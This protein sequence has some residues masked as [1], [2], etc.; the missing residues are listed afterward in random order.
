[1]G[2]HRFA[3]VRIEAEH[4]VAS[5]FHEV[6][7]LV[8][9]FAVG[10]G[11]GTGKHRAGFYLFLS[12]LEPAAGQGASENSASRGWSAA[13]HRVTIGTQSTRN[14]F[15]SVLLPPWRA[16]PAGAFAL[17]WLADDGDGVPVAARTP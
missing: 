17:V 10:G 3:P 16:C 2:R 1:M 12:V 15:L 14:R 4:D 6:V 11:W 9:S 5:L 8:A 7:Q 13:G